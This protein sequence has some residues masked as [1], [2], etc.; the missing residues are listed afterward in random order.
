M[1]PLFPGSRVGKTPI[2]FLS[3]C[4]GILLRLWLSLRICVSR[5][6]KEKNYPK[7]IRKLQSE[8]LRERTS[9]LFILK[10]PL[11]TKHRQN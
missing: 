3:E 1:V 11:F 9:D 10:R 5:R 7:A 6:E 4:E 8:A 2:K